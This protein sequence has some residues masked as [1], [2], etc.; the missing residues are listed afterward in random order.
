MKIFLFF[1]ISLPDF[2]LFSIDNC[3]YILFF[4]ALYASTKDQNILCFLFLS[5]EHCHKKTKMN[6]SLPMSSPEPKCLNVK[7]VHAMHECGVDKDE[8]I[9]CNCN[10]ARDYKSQGSMS[11]MAY[12][13]RLSKAMRNEDRARS[14]C[15]CNCR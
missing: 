7:K 4:R 5:I 9:K 14:L 6:L 15:N 12:N 11:E 13:L 8:S 1:S 2:S 10:L 3:R